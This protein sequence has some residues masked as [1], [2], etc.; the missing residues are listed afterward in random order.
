M[1]PQMPSAELV[2]MGHFVRPMRA[3]DIAQVARV[4]NDCF[5]SGWT[6]TPFMRE[7][8]NSR[9]R[10]LVACEA[11]QPTQA[12]DEASVDS[13]GEMKSPKSMLLRFLSGLMA[14]LGIEQPPAQDFVH[15]IAGYVGI[16]FLTDEAHIT[17]IGTLESERR[18]GIGELLLMASIEESSRQGSRVVTLE[19]RVSN[20]SAQALYAKYGFKRAGI[21][22]GYY[23][24]NREDALIMTTD[25]LSNKTY[26]ELFNQVREAHSNRWGPSVRI[27][28]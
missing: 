6:P 15:K 21:R 2:P 10:Y 4:E 3:Q 26:L 1:G 11:H 23:N 9:A 16:W 17:A 14:L 24:D 12:I 27:L 5:P 13:T 8:K 25:N 20:H 18:K 7:L 28:A 22:K 19:T